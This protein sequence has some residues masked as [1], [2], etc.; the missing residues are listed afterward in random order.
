MGEANL[1][2]QVPLTPRPVGFA[3]RAHLNSAGFS[4]LNSQHNSSMHQYDSGHGTRSPRPYARTTAGLLA[5]ASATSAHSAGGA[6]LAAN[7]EASGGP[8]FARMSSFGSAATDSSTTAPREPGLAPMSSTETTDV[9]PTLSGHQL[10]SGNN[11]GQGHIPTPPN[12]ARA[13]SYSP[14]QAGGM[15]RNQLAAAASLLSEAERTELAKLLTEMNLAHPGGTAPPH[16][17]R[18]PSPPP[19][20][21]EPCI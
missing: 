10:S 20:L 15:A 21:P 14:P 13:R 19:D 1:C 17:Q 7:L 5:Y 11:S 12:A 8:Y 18:S 3:S 2:P 6:A 4:S 9:S 16:C